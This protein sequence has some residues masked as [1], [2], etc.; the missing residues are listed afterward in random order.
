MSILCEEAENTHFYFFVSQLASFLAYSSMA[1]AMIIE[2]ESPFFLD[3]SFNC[4]ADGSGNDIWIFVFVDS[5]MTY[6]ILSFLYI[7]P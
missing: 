5:I 7:V 6:S 3:K 1:K 4:F 2:R